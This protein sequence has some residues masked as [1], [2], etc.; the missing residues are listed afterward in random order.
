M[1]KTLKE[2]FDEAAA[3]EGVYALLLT[4]DQARVTLRALKQASG[5]DAEAAIARSRLARLLSRRWAQ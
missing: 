5:D 4:G 1:K 2:A 3:D